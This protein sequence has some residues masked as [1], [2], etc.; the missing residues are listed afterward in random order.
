MTG[1]AYVRRL[2]FDNSDNLFAS[3]ND[4]VRK[5]DTN[6]TVS[7]NSFGGKLKFV[8]DGINV[9][10]YGNL[11]VYDGSNCAVRKI[12]PNGVLQPVPIVSRLSHNYG[13]M[14]FDS[15]PTICMLQITIMALF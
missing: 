3:I 2:A 12:A 6:G 7:V 13:A 10:R 14:C 9:D 4:S 11:Y 1:S 8:A 5:F 15:A